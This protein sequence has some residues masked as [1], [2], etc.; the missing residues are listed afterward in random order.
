M[1]GLSELSNPREQEFLG[2]ITRD[3]ATE[4]LRSDVANAEQAVNTYVTVPLTQNQF[5]ALVSFTY[6]LGDDNL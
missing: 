2:G 5:D 1:W 4:L 6:N 3:R